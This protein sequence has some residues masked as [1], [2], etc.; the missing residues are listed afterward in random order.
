[1]GRPRIG[2]DLLTVLQVMKQRPRMFMRSESLMLLEAYIDGFEMC[3]RANAVDLPAGRPSWGDFVVGLRSKYQVSDQRGWVSI[4]R[5]AHEGADDESLFE[6]FFEE[7]EEF[8]GQS[9]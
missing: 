1:M 7:L 4:L 6:I 3:G 5:L 9:S 2:P 8:L